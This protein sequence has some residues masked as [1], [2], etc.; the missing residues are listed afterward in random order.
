[1]NVMWYPGV[2][3]VATYDCVL[4]RMVR[5]LFTLPARKDMDQLLNYY[6]K[7]NAQMSISVGRY[8]TNTIACIATGSIHVHVHECVCSMDVYKT[9]AQCTCVHVCV[10]ACTLHVHPPLPVHVYKCVFTIDYGA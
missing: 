7:Q 3:S 8:D 5:L 10:T 6:F 1:M 4:Y 2:T 9:V